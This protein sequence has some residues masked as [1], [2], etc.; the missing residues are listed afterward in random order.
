MMTSNLLT[1]NAT[2]S[3]RFHDLFKPRD[4]FLHDGKSLRRFTIGA[5]IQMAAALGIFVLLAWSIIATFTAFA[6]MNGDVARMQRQVASMEAD[7]A[8]MRVAVHDRAESLERRQAFLAEMLSGN[9]SV[10][11]LAAQLPQAASQPTNPAAQAMSQSFAEVEDMQ[12]NLLQRAQQVTRQRYHQ[13]AATLRRL[14][15]TPGRFHQGRAASGM[16]GPYEPVPSAADNADPRF[17]ALFTSWRALEQLQ[18]G[19]SGIPS[20]R[21]IQTSVNFTSGFGIR[22]DPFRGRA[23]MHAGIDLA[24]PVGTPVYATADGIVG[25]SEWNNGGYGNLVELDH[26]QGIQTRYGHLSR[27]IAFAGQR[28]RRGDLIGLMG[29]TGRSTGNHLHYEVRIDG[30]AVNPVPFMQQ[31]SQTMIALQRPA[32]P[33]VAVGGPAGGSR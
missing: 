23:A 11:R 22:S 20:A 30:R 32:T 6:A 1:A 12:E 27:R 24:G 25:R 33:P 9:A 16:G 28:I 21:P 26:G 31:P 4:V 18:L 3:S 15:L 5:K 29:S 14:G 10:D 19:V 2:L 7:V 17:L 8:A 13:T